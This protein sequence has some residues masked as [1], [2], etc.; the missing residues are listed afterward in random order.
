MNSFSPTFFNYE[1]TG[2]WLISVRQSLNLLFLASILRPAVCFAFINLLV[3]IDVTAPLF[4][5]ANQRVG[6]PPAQL[7]P[8]Q[9][10]KSLINLAKRSKE[11]REN[12]S[13]ES[14][15]DRDHVKIRPNFFCSSFKLRTRSILQWIQES[16]H[17]HRN[18]QSQTNTLETLD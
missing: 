1:T 14:A 7:S 11:L 15:K 4:P 12:E 2:D 5:K 8:G 9:R 18:I 6:G 17:N 3:I 16:S 10:I 13:S